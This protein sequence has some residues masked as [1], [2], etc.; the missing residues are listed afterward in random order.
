MNSKN[1]IDDIGSKLLSQG[2]VQLRGEG[3]TGDGKQELS[4][5][6]TLELEVVEE[7]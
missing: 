5:N 2:A 1:G 6:G 3:G 7:L 4:V